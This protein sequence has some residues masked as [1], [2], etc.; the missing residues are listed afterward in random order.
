MHNVG[1]TQKLIDTSMDHTL[2]LTILQE[3]ILILESRVQEL[4]YYLEQEASI[5]LIEQRRIAEANVI[6]LEKQMEQTT[7][8][9]EQDRLLLEKKNKMKSSWNKQNIN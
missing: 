3:T 8:Q 5:Q 4:Q 6:A 9:G 1:A 7:I 2:Q